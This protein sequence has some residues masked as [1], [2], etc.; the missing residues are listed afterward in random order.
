MQEKCKS[1]SDI[2]TQM[3]IQKH[4]EI[5]LRSQQQPKQHS[6]NWQGAQEVTESLQFKRQVNE[7]GIWQHTK[8]PFP[9]TKNS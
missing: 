6:T 2:G 8:P 9:T 7:N 1:D 3:N 4:T 5:A